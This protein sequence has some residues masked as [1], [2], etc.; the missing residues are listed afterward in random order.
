MRIDG[1]NHWQPQ[2]GC[3]ILDGRRA[4]RAASPGRSIR[5]SDYS[6][7]SIPRSQRPQHRDGEIRGAEEYQTHGPMVA[8]LGSRP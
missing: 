1:L 7:D 8:R 2:G 6:G 3:R 5:L 4:E